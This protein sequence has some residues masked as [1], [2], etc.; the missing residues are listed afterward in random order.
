VAEAHDISVEELAALNN[1]TVEDLR[2]LSIGDELI[3]PC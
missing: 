1:T 3:V 2:T